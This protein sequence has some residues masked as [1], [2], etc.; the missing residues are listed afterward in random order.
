ML[1]AG[2]RGCSETVRV[3][4]T[5]VFAAGIGGR[6]GEAVRVQLSTALRFSKK[7]GDEVPED[8][9]N[10]RL[11]VGRDDCSHPLCHAGG[12]RQ[13]G[14]PQGDG[15]ETTAHSFASHDSFLLSRQDGGMVEIGLP[16]LP[17]RTTS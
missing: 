17:L 6:P 13:Q 8:G 4:L 11:G 10:A 2:I 16:R 3:D 1:A 14:E 7:T 15:G 12:R 9:E 5:P